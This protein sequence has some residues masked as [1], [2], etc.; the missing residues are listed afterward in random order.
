M[1]L[2]ADFA[3]LDSASAIISCGWI[4]NLLEFVETFV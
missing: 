1:S 2:A 3:V 4:L